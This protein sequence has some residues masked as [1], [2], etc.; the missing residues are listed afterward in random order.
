MDV[1]TVKHAIE[2]IDLPPNGPRLALQP[3]LVWWALFSAAVIDWPFHKPRAQTRR[4][5]HGD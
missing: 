3:V 4:T 5:P 2:A 1:V